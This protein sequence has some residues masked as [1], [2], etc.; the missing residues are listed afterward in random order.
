MYRSWLNGLLASFVSKCILFDCCFKILFM[1]IWKSL[2][3]LNRLSWIRIVY[4]Y[5]CKVVS[6]LDLHILCR[7]VYI[8][9]SDFY[10]TLMVAVL[11]FDYVMN[12]AFVVI[13]M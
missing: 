6:C 11:S 5:D 4:D 10:N 2:C 12:I 3:E 7:I 13:I 9:S 1:A 8:F